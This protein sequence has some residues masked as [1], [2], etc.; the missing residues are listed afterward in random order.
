MDCQLCSDPGARYLGYLHD[1]M[2]PDDADAGV[3]LPDGRVVT[4]L[5]D[6]CGDELADYWNAVEH[7]EAPTTLFGEVIP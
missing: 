7:G 5:C 4:W 3:P 2:H 6:P 1:G